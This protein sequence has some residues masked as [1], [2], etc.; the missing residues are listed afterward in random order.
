V[1]YVY[2]GSFWIEVSGGTGFTAS[3]VND[4]PVSI[5]YLD[6]ATSNIQQQLNVKAP[7]SSPALTGIP[8]ST[9]AALDT[10]TTQ[11]ATTAYVVGQ[12]YAKLAS[13]TFSGT[14]VLPSTTSIGNITST[15]LGYIDGLT[16]S[17]QTQINTKAPAASPTFTGTVVLPSTTSI[18][19]VDATEISYLDGVTSGIQT[20]IN[21]KLAT[22]AFTY[23]NI[24]KA[25]YAN[26]GSLP[27]SAS[28]TGKVMY[29]QADGYMYYSTGSTWVKVA[30]FNDTTSLTYNINALTD[31]DTGTV[32]PLIN[33]VLGWD[34][35]NWVPV[36]QNSASPNLALTDINDVDTST[37]PSIGD[38]LTYNGTNWAPGAVSAY[39]SDLTDASNAGLSVDQFWLPA[40]T[41]LF[42][43]ADGM[44]GYK[45]GAQYN[46]AT[47]PT[48]WALSGTT[49]SFLL[50]TPGH[51]FLIQTAAG[52]N[53]NTGLI[54]V[55]PTGVISDGANAQG[56]TSGTLYW[57][58]PIDV[59]GNYKYQCSIHAGMTGVITV[60]DLRAI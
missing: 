49:I 59:S 8:T 11:I 36:N 25:T 4:L 45:F 30:K 35:T 23:A 44:T 38:V 28:N 3:G 2:D 37:P 5:G 57:T 22:T 29:V 16:S 14:V 60:K 7:L 31:V 41:Q 56:K 55:S 54:H 50:N 58:V 9:T 17:A 18:G 13:P 19:T 15:E 26:V 53:Y 33:Q 42:V 40:I 27:A 6:G 48:L 46:D 20:Q 1:L 39:F 43:T 10:N 21:S 34:G 24:T 12:G 52:V 32:A 47:N 51:P